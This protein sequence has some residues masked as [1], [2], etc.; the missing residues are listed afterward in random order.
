MDTQDIRTLKILEAIDGQDAPSQRDMAEAL[1]ISLGLINSFIRR[2]A[3]KGYFK[4]THLPKNRMRYI[5][6]PQGVTEK[7]RL[8]YAYIQYSYR[9]YRDA[10]H[11]TRNL[12]RELKADGV[13]R[14]AF[15]GEGDL[16]EIAYLSLQES[17]LS[18]VA[19]GDCTGNDGHFFGHPILGMDELLETIFDAVVL[20][21]ERLDPDLV[22]LLVEKGVA[23]SKIKTF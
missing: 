23:K 20:T 17:D 8:T 4:V 9:F 12:F 10:R 15:F 19:I 1:N 7:T 2:L 22:G 6:T 5:L 11:R 21:N 18:F 3:K 16:A 13:E 14:V